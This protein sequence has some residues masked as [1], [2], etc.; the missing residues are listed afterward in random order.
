MAYLFWLGVSLGC[1][2]VLMLHHLVGGS[3][4]AMIQRILEAGTRTLPLMAILFIPILLGMGF[5][6]EWALPS[7][8]A[9]DPILQA[10]RWYL[11]IPFFLI[12]AV[13]FFAVWLVLAHYL[14]HW[15]Q[16]HEETAGQP[17]PG[18]L[19]LSYPNAECRWHF[20]L[21]SDHVLRLVRLGHVA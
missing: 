13:I 7:V 1:L 21:W 20:G 5:L 9:H 15:S 16:R 19:S 17:A 2:A 3:W 4:G 6:Y 8:V 11:N 10:K 14:N 12:R 18:N